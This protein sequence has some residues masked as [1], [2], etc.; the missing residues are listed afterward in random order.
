MIR[1]GLSKHKNNKS[2][3]VS[4]LN[5][6]VLK[7]LTSPLFIDCLVIFFNHVGR[8]GAPS[9]WT[10]VQFTSLYKN[11]GA[12]SE[13]SNYRGLSVSGV[14]PKLYAICINILLEREA[15]SKGIRADT[16]A[17]FRPGYRVEDNCILLRAV[18]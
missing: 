1:L 6:E 8:K 16:Q 17:G 9:D 4:F 15:T 11:K 5:A 13:G 3:G 12:R 18:M 2:C 10:E 14:L 7:S